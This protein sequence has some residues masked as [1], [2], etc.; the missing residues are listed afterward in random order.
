MERATKILVFGWACT[1]LAFDVWLVARG[2]GALTPLAA[3][4]FCIA[5]ICSAFDER[6][7]AVVLVLTYIFPALIRPLAGSYVPQF[8][9]AWLAAVLG[10]VAPRAIRTRWYLPRQ[11][12]GPLVCWALIVAVGTVIVVARELDFNVDLLHNDQLWSSIGGLAP[13]NVVTWVVH[14]GLL[15]VI[16]I[17]WFDWLLGA[18]LD[19]YTWIAAPLALSCAMMALVAVYQMFGDI[20]FLN[21]TVFGGLGRASGTVFDGNVCGVLAA[22]WI[23]GAILC[24]IRFER[25]RTLILAIG[26]PLGWLAVW[27]T[28]SRTAFASAALVTVASVFALYVARR[29]PSRPIRPTYVAL[30]AAIAVALAVALAH[31]PLAVVGPIARVRA[32]LPGLSLSSMRDFLEETWNRNRYGAVATKMIRESPFVGVG[33]GSFQVLLPDFAWSEGML[34]SDNAQNWYRHQL[35]EFGAIGSAGWI[36]WLFVFSGF[37]LKRQRAAAARPA[38]WIASGMLFAFALISL[39][40]MPGQESM[41]MLSLWTFVFWYSSIVGLPE[42]GGRLTA[43]SWLLVGV[44]LILYGGGTT[45]EAFTRLRVPVRAQTAGWPY[46]YGF[47]EPEKDG[48]GGE[49][50]WS[51]RRAVAVVKASAHGMLLNASSNFPDLSSKPVGVKVWC[52]GKLVVDAHL[53]T[54]APVSKYVRLPTAERW[55]VIETRVGRVVRPR[56]FGVPDDRE[57]GVM[58][59]WN[60]VD[61]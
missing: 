5:A 28:G 52:D 60:F 7:A 10:V 4:A 9:V 14:V 18:K 43:R 36:A 57:L 54:S 26:V 46:S 27:A 38:S 56:E 12:Q 33:V 2:W 39:V 20:T 15:L 11:W 51:G 48:A 50:R 23:G 21:E 3:G 44:V 61:Y 24:G 59:S 31:T 37:V 25:W 6:I 58:L 53:S 16:G 34:V 1:A 19:F 47:F 13:P 41:V 55:V 45:V 35:A 17:L 32:T 8:D 22:L 40:G 30:S 49:F 42:S 29:Q